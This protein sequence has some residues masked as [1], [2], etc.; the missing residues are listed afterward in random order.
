MPKVKF[1]DSRIR[2]KIIEKY[3][4]CKEFSKHV[5]ESPTTISRLLRGHGV[6]TQY[7]IY[8]WAVVLGMSREDIGYYFFNF[9]IEVEG[10]D[11]EK[12]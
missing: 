8:E 12:R 9:D 6:F 3:G 11:N 7:I 10:E 4:S 2:G 1:D 5:A